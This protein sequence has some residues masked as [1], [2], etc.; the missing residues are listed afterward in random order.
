MT[1]QV[2][3]SKWA[4]ATASSSMHAVALTACL[5]VGESRRVF[6]DLAGFIGILVNN[7]CDSLLVQAVSYA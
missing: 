5:A 7:T 2:A 4:K 3:R 6:V 1:V